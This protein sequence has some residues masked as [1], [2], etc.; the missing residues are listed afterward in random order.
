MLSVSP[1]NGFLFS[2]VWAY[3]FRDTIYQCAS[4]WEVV[5]SLCSQIAHNSH[6]FLRYIRH[7]SLRVNK[8]R[9]AQFSIKW[10]N[11][12][13]VRVPF[14]CD[15][16]LYWMPRLMYWGSYYVRFRIYWWVNYLNKQR[17][18]GLCLQLKYVNH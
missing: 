11:W 8:S 10:V 15:D 3:A 13:C 1:F 14:Q 17:D 16:C 9:S 6:C 7:Q 18:T 12:M 2:C 4:F 5:L